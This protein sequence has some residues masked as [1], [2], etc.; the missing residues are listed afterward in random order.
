MPTTNV[1][2]FLGVPA[3][4]V[5]GDALLPLDELDEFAVDGLDVFVESDDESPPHAASNDVIPSVPTAAAAPLRTWRR[6]AIR[7]IA[8]GKEYVIISHLLDATHILSGLRALKCVSAESVPR[9]LGRLM[10]FPLLTRPP[11]S[12][13]AKR[14]SGDD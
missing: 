14:N 6:D 5:D 8:L 13:A 1:P 9:I 2:P 7:R 3:L 11:P 4:S 12:A 10:M